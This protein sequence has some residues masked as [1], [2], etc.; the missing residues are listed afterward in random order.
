MSMIA[1]RG[2]DE[3]RRQQEDLPSRTEAVRRLVA[4]ALVG[5]D[6]RPMASA[7]QDKAA[8]LASHEIDK[9]GDQ[10]ATDD[11]RA[12]RKRHLV[13]GPRE[14]RGDR[15]KGLASKGGKAKG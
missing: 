9:M 1:L 3:W 8:D 2:I 10:S 4:I 14:F 5:S 6:T 12:S 15:S 13:K 7:A 11:Q